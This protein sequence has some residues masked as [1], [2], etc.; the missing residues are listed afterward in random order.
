MFQQHR[1]QTSTQDTQHRSEP[2]PNST[3]P[4]ANSLKSSLT[5]GVQEV[6]VEIKDDGGHA[7]GDSIILGEPPLGVQQGSLKNLLV[8]I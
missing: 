5:T 3:L 8:L 7:A 4:F 1:A 2:F 6:D